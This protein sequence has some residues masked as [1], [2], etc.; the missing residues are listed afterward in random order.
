MIS[1]LK[2]SLSQITQLIFAPGDK[3]RLRRNIGRIRN[4]IFLILLSVLLWFVTVRTRL[5]TSVR[6]PLLALRPFW[7]VLLLWSA[8]LTYLSIRRLINVLR[9]EPSYTPFP[10]MEENWNYI[11][12]AL[13]ESNVRPWELPVIIV[14]GHRPLEGVHY[15]DNLQPRLRN[16]RMRRDSELLFQADLTDSAIIITCQNASLLGTITR[17]MELGRTPS[18]GN[19][20]QNS[21][22]N[23]NRV[24]STQVIGLS[25]EPENPGT[26]KTATV[27]SPQATVLESKS[28]NDTTGEMLTEEEIRLTSLK[29]KY[30]C[31][32]IAADRYP[33][34]PIN[35]VI[36]TVPK[37][38]TD[39]EQFITN[40]I[41]LSRIDLHSIRQAT[42]L[43]FPFAVLGTNMH[44]LRGFDELVKQLDSGSKRRYL[45]FALHTRLDISTDQWLK[46]IKKGMR[47][48]RQRV[49]PALVL[50]E[51][52]E[53]PPS[54]L[55]AQASSRGPFIRSNHS[56]YL[57]LQNAGRQWRNLEYFCSRIC[58]YQLKTISGNPRFAG[59]FITGLEN[60][61]TG[62]WLFIHEFFKHMLSQQ[63][64]IS[65]T[66]EALSRDRQQKRLAILILTLVFVIVGIISVIAIW[67]FMK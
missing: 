3:T 37:E 57:F 64:S 19:F 63:D 21:I 28:H 41:E 46:Q 29:L 1:S 40:A 66:P 26:A 33:F 42:G 48:I 47:W 51:M 59:L 8:V 9:T 54:A 49:L 11:K 4:F 13:L 5:D 18:L 43:D 6:A 53:L 58:E 20:K 32:L 34:C 44:H 35:G 52:L 55:S 61:E 36:V 16:L 45:G 56:S 23:S 31:D 60:N 12:A 65:W 39:S 27:K 62:P 30:L 10:E 24:T 14:L 50:R 25:A 15:F 7:L 22:L 2:K 17:R 67:I 38:M